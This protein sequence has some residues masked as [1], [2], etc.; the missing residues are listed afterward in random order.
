MNKLQDESNKLFNINLMFLSI[1][2]IDT[3]LLI[4]DYKW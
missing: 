3:R 2:A 4:E 1:F